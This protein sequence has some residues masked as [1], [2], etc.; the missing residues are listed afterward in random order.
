MGG[1]AAKPAIYYPDYFSADG[2]FGRYP[3]LLPNLIACISITFA[4]IQGCL[5]MEETNP[6]FK[7]DSAIDDDEDEGEVDE[8]TPLNHQ[9]RNRDRSNSVIRAIR[10]SRNSQSFMEES[11]PMPIDQHFD[12]RRQSFGTMHSITVPHDQHTEEPESS[13]PQ[14][15]YTYSVMMITLALIII[16]YHQMAFI[17]NIPVWILDKP[18]NPFGQVDLIGGLGYSLHDVGTYLAVNGFIALFI[19]GVVF[20]PFVETIGVWKSY[21]I[22]LT[23]YPTL[24][25]IIPFISALPEPL[26]S[27][28]VYLVFILQ[29]IF[30]IIV[31]P[32][33]LILL[34]NVTPSPSV[35]GRVNGMAMSACCLARTVSSPLTGAIYS[36]GGSAAAWWSLGIVSILGIVQLYWIPTEHIG[37]VSVESGIKKGSRHDSGHSGDTDESVIES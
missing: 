15:T 33:A 31:Y 25:F 11:M 32:C 21:V 2:V 7:T 22:M 23:L 14:K 29:D 20:P 6:A 8:R 35:L 37:K 13:E 27:P 5:F 28:G 4:I 30:G 10:E 34:K 19:Q 26:V 36:I 12:I 9:P 24:Y 17:A 16:C 1:F 3:Y 18:R